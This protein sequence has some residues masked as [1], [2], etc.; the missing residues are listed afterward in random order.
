MKLLQNAITPQDQSRKHTVLLESK[1]LH[2]NKWFKC[3]S[4]FKIILLAIKNLFWRIFFTPLRSKICLNNSD[5]NA[6]GKQCDFCTLLHFFQNYRALWRMWNWWLFL[7]RF[8]FS[9]R[10][11]RCNTN[12]FC[13]NPVVLNH[14]EDLR[15]I[16]FLRNILRY[17]KKIW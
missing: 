7:T 1:K 11:N 4:E 14:L 9:T 10:G 5:F 6:Q 16:W 12:F 13:S 17:A 8:T 15:V 3:S 2:H